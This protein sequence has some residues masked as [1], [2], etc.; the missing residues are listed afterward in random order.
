MARPQPQHRLIHLLIRILQY[1]AKARLILAAP[2]LHFDAI[3]WILLTFI[4]IFAA[5]T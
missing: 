3:L 4:A 5:E 2:S 1:I